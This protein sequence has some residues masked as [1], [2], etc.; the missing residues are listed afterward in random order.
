M[1]KYGI[2]HLASKA[3]SMIQKVV[4]Q[5]CQASEVCSGILVHTSMYRYAI[6]PEYE[7]MYWVVLRLNTTQFY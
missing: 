1:Y 3:D 2:W 4:G 7:G 5:F 6:L